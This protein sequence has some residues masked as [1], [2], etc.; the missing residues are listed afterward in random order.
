MDLLG[1]LWGVF[2]HADGCTSDGI[3]ILYFESFQIPGF[4]T[5]GVLCYGPYWPVFLLALFWF[6]RKLLA[7]P[8]LSPVQAASRLSAALLALSLFFLPLPLPLSFSLPHFGAHQAPTFSFFL[9]PLAFPF[10]L[11]F[12]YEPP[13]AS[14]LSLSPHAATQN[15]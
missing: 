12:A 4:V 9:Q 7:S 15:L 13:L 6:S 5:D 3:W 2:H 8:S 10:P 11:L 1:A 14:L